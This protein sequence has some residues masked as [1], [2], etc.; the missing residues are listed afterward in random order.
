MQP[1]S[2][3]PAIRVV[4]HL[5][6]ISVFFIIRLPIMA[7]RTPTADR[8]AAGCFATTRWS[9]ILKAGGLDSA[10]AFEALTKLC[11]SY[12]YPLY[13]HARRRGR[14]PQDAADLTQEFFRRFLEKG[15]LNRADPERGRFRSFLLTSLNNFLANEHDRSTAVKRGG[16]LLALDDVA[17]EQRY[18]FETPG[19]AVAERAFDRNWALAVMR[20]AIERLAEECAGAGKAPL[21]RALQ[22]FLARESDKGEYARLAE[23]LGLS[24]NSVAVAVHRLRERY[25]ELVRQQV[26]ETVGDPADVE[27]EL[28]Y[29]LTLLA[30]SV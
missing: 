20:C 13:S 17:A 24:A 23:G 27:D 25:R 21:F 29:L 1:S 11:E 8:P 7:L 14:S 5:T 19:A 22:P 28:R 15:Y 30:E 10:E 3:Q 6:A 26:A 18:Q 12:W 4:S 16:A 2:A 9:L